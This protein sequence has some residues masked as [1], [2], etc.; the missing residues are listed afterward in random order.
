MWIGAWRCFS[1]SLPWA[2]ESRE[3]AGESWGVKSAACDL[4]FATARS[5]LWKL[6]VLGSLLSGRAISRWETV[7]SLLREKSASGAA[8]TS[9]S[10]AYCRRVLPPSVSPNSSVVIR[11]IH[12]FHGS[13][14]GEECA[15]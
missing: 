12:F 13:D 10:G 4:K 3:R 8:K 14:P 6:Q 9:S 15:V 11:G 5:S 7:R 2:R 1:R